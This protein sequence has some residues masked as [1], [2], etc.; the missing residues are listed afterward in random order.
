MNPLLGHE[1][2]VSAF[3]AALGSGRMHH[4]WL[5]AG[6]QGVGK[7]RFAEAAAWRIL[8]EGAGEAIAAEAITPDSGQTATLMAARSHPDFMRVAREVWQK[9]SDKERLVPYADRK[10]DEAPARSIRV[11]QI[12][13]L[14]RALALAPSLSKRR[15]IL[16]DAAEDCEVS[17][18]NALLKILEE[19]PAGCVFL[20]VSHAPGRLLPTIR[21]RCRLLR[22]DPLAEAD[23]RQVLRTGLPHADAGELD[24]LA[25]AGQGS[26]GRALGYAGLDI[27]GIDA[28]LAQIAATGDPT[29]ELRHDLAHKLSLKS[30]ARRYE[31]FL[32]RAPA[33]VGEA[34]RVRS[35][36][37]LEGAIRTYEEVRRLSESA[38]RQSLDPQMTV[39]TLAGM[40][41]GLHAA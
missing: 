41:A 23:V 40:V 33:F 39:F 18:S 32:G 35:G 5:L 14:H 24:A 38:V 30:A 28:A 4:A 36:T 21:S 6:P 19:P 13:W 17:A 22:F 31:A 29:T 25:A 1:A 10:P 9:G 20:L 7:A 26:P 12:R 15:V 16:I 3:L 27:A 11:V 2:Q 8:A 37:A 34:A